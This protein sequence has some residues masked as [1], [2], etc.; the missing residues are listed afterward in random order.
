MTAPPVDLPGPAGRRAAVRR[1]AGLWG[2]ERALWRAGF[3]RVAGVDEAGRGA[4]AGPLVIAAAVLPDGRRG[5]VPGLADS[6]LL[7]PAARERVYGEV[8]ARA[9]DWSVVIV[10]PAEVDSVGLHRSNVAGMRRALARLGAEPSYVLTDG[11]PVAGTGAPALAVWK[12]DRVSA[13]IAA[14]S[15]IAKVTRDRIMTELHGRFPRYD[16]AT[17][18]GYVTPHHQAA[19]AAHGPCAEHRFSYVNVARVSGRRSGALVDP[20]DLSAGPGEPVE[21]P[22][23]VS[24]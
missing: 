19:L 5:I 15:V 9:E 6:K 4:C 1:D 18:K 23:G 24:S 14:A 10:P 11:F 17:H 16:F 2:Y 3:D 13:C 21:L 12:G 20:D 7:T 8:V 22:A